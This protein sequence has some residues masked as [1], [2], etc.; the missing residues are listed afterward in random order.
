MKRIETTKTL[1][2]KHD[3]ENQVD[4]ESPEINGKDKK[5]SIK[6]KEEIKRKV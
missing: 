1:K 4:T 3:P 6:K 2:N 5:K